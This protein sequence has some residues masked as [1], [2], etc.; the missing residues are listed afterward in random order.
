VKS[1]CWLA[2]LGCTRTHNRRRQIETGRDQVSEKSRY[3]GIGGITHYRYT[4]VYYTRL[5]EHGY[6]HEHTSV[7][8]TLRYYNG[9]VWHLRPY[10]I[11]RCP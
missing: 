3:R 5:R 8:V 10:T 6:Y 7:Y 11:T 1:H 2:H 4:Q 9:R